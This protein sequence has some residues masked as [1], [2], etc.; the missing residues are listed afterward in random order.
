MNKGKKIEQKMG[1]I[2][3]DGHLGGFLDG[4]DDGTYYPE[5]WDYLVDAYEIKTVVDIGCGKGFSTAY[6]KSLGCEVLGIDG[7]EKAKQMSLIPENFLL[8]DYTKQSANIKKYDLGWSCEFL[9][10]V[11]EKYQE[12]YMNDFKKCKYVAIT[13]AGKKQWGHH[14][15][16]CNDE[17]YW[18]DV[19][20]KNNFQ[21]LKNETL[22]MRALSKLHFKERGL[23]LKN[24]Q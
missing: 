11:E 7:S 1:K 20:T 13:F 10:H 4:G 6:F 19:F 14:H 21:Y 16:N 24:E 9:E 3:V 2:I 12:N 15:V 17:N 23:F 8:N 18:I 5:L 22:A